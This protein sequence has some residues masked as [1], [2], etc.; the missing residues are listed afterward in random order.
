MKHAGGDPIEVRRNTPSS[1]QLPLFASGASVRS[2]SE[3]QSAVHDAIDGTP[4]RLRGSFA[5]SF[6]A[7]ALERY[8]ELT[9]RRTGHAL[10]RPPEGTRPLRASAHEAAVALAEVASAMPAD[11]AAYLIGSAYSAA[12]PEDV[13]ARQGVFYTPPALVDRLIGQVELAGIDWSTSHVLDPACGGGAFLAPIAARMCEALK[14]CDR[15]VILR[16]IAGRLRGYEIDDFAAWISRVFLDVT[17][18]ERLGSR[19]LA[20]DA[21]IEV[22]DSLTRLEDVMFDAVIGNPPY[23]RVTLS[24]GQRETFKRGLYGHANMY[25]LFLQLAVRKTRPGGVIGFVTPTSFLGGEY[26]KRLR[27]LLASDANPVTLDLVKE[28]AGVFDGVLQETLLTVCRRGE[29]SRAPALHF[30]GSDEDARAD[31]GVAMTLPNDPQAP[32]VLPRSRADVA[33]A[34]RLRALPTRLADWGYRVSTGPL[35]WNRHKAQLRSRAERGAIPLV[36]AESVGTDGTFYFR[37]SRRNHLPY[38]SPLDGDEWLLVREPCALLQR[39]TSKEQPRRLVCAEL[40]GTFLAEHGAV[41]VENHLN[42]LVRLHAA[43]CVDPRTL[44]A[45][46]NSAAADRAFR[47]LSGSVAVSAYELEAMPLPDTHR[48]TALQRAVQ[49]NASRAELDQLCE[50]LYAEGG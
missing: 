16:N 47:C 18:C 20:I 25:G 14:R 40:P 7:R 1:L 6:C 13:R 41:T 43:P 19:A 9:H 3:A 24:A 30:I 27:G 48:V 12:L 46:L 10:R 28:R 49:A 17:L 42:M 32:W 4:D 29:V 31:P 50:D 36:W 23:G 2:L 22:T 44:A 35:V 26:F 5:R 45:F 11:H 15:R 37:A 38:F 21:L 39:T 33:F 34:T 8:W